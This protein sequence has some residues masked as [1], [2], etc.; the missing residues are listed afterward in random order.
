MKEKEEKYQF[1]I[2]EE[3]NGT[4]IDLVLSNLLADTSRSFI[5]KLLKRTKLR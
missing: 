3:Q 2:D 5:Q 4:R 1:E